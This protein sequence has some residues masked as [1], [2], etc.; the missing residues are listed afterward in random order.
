MGLVGVGSAT[1]SASRSQG[2]QVVLSGSFPNWQTA[3]DTLSQYKLWEGP[4]ASADFGAVAKLVQ[5]VRA[6]QAWE[7][8]PTPAPAPYHN[9]GENHM[10]GTLI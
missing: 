5:R 6:A 8:S 10:V 9:D 2:Q 7:V 1:I 4:V 3:T